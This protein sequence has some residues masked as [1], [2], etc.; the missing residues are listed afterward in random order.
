MMNSAPIRV[1]IRILGGKVGRDA[2]RG[3]QSRSQN[4][5]VSDTHAHACL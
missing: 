4:A 1:G 5:I 2:N 3:A